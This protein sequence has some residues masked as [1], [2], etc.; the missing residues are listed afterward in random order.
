MPIEYS[1]LLIFPTA[2]THP[3]IDSNMR[4]INSGPVWPL[5]LA[6]MNYGA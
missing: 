1:T 3:M 6:S 4:Q 2:V 5:A